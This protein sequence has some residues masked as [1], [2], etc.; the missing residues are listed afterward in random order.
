MTDSNPE[1]NTILGTKELE[2]HIEA[3]L[4][5]AKEDM[6]ISNLPL[7]KNISPLLVL[8]PS[9]PGFIPFTMSTGQ[10]CI[11]PKNLLRKVWHPYQDSVG[12]CRCEPGGWCDNL[13]CS[14][15]VQLVP[16]KIQRCGS[17]NGGSWSGR[18]C[19]S[20][21]KEPCNQLRSSCSG[22]TPTCTPCLGSPEV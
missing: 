9:I 1:N 12:Q 11:P 14:G 13:P 7:L 4:E 15:Q 10:H 21:D 5:E 17:L 22:H 3:F 19:C 2:A 16:H 8:A 20:T 18:S 6:E